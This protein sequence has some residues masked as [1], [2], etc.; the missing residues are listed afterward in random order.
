[1]GLNISD[2]QKKKI[3]AEEENK[4]NEEKEINELDKEL[5]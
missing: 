3:K 5:E 4:K 1:M 2:I